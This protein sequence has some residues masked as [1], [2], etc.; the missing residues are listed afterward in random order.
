VSKLGLLIRTINKISK[1][2]G[3]ILRFFV[4]GIIFIVV[5]EIV[6]R[7]VFNH[8][9]IWAQETSIFLFGTYAV[10]SG[11]YVYYLN[12]H[13]R[14]DVLYGR[15][16]SRTKAIVDVFTSILVFIF[17]IAFLWWSWGLALKSFNARETV[18]ISL[19]APPYYPFKFMFPLGAFL[20]LLQVVAKFLQDIVTAITGGS[21]SEH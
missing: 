7:T 15:L 3:A 11:A 4:L 10:L 9:T 5:Y 19:W 13:V 14:M 21:R 6:A 18:G 17:V 1:W 20:L 16:S 12:G 2:S 8:A